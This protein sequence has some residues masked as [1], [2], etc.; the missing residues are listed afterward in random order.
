MGAYD[1]KGF[2]KSG[3]YKNMDSDNHGT[4]TWK[5][6]N[7]P[8]FSNQS[9]YHGADGW[10]GGN[11]TDKT[12]YQPSKQTLETY[13]PD[14]YDWMFKSEPGRSEYLDMSRY[15][16]GLNKP[17]PFVYQ[18]GGRTPIYVSDPDD[19]RLKAYN[20]STDAYDFGVRSIKE[21]NAAIKK[22]KEKGTPLKNIPKKH[23]QGLTPWV[24]TN[25]MPI[26]T[27]HASPTGTKYGSEN[28]DFTLW[29]FYTKFKKPVQPVQYKPAQKQVSYPNQ[30]IGTGMKRSISK[31]TNSI[32][33]SNPTPIY[34]NDPNDPRLK[35]YNDSL[36][37]Y[38]KEKR[39]Y[40]DETKL[41]Y[42][43]LLKYP[44]SNPSG[45]R[46]G[47]TYSNKPLHGYKKPVQ[48]IKYADPKIVAKQQQLIDA[49]YNIGT[50]DGIW[51][52]KSQQAWDQMNTPKQSNVNASF[53]TSTMPVRGM[54][55]EN[56]DA[57]KKQYKDE[58]G[59]NFKSQDNVF[60]NLQKSLG[61]RPTVTEYN[62][63]IQQYNS[64]VNNMKY[65]GWLDSYQEGG[66]II[67]PDETF[68]GIAN[69]YGFNKQELI[70][71]NP[72]LDI[73]KI[74]PGQKI[75][76]PTV[77]KI[78]EVNISS[79]NK[80]EPTSWYDYINPFNWGAPNYDD[81]GTFKQAFRKAR[82]EDKNDFM[83]Y[84]DRYSSDLAQLPENKKDIVK[85]NDIKI[86]R[87]Y[88]NDILYKGLSDV[89]KERRKKLLQS[90]NKIAN[91]QDNSEA[92]E[93]LLV[94]TAVMENTLGA[95]KNAYGRT[96]TRNPMSIDDI[97]YDDLFKVRKGAKDHTKSQKQA[98]DWLKTLG[99]DYR[100]MDKILRSDDP[101]AGMAAARLYYGRNTKPLPKE[102]NKDALYNYYIEA[103]NKGGV[104]KYKGK[105]GYKDKWDKYYN[106]VFPENT[107][108]KKYGGWLDSYQDGGQTKWLNNYK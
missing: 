42:D 70:N 63:A 33:K 58:F 66:H 12:G 65:G 50:A 56:V 54:T 2:W 52:K 90:A 15:E 18:K 72:G 3:D 80:K 40:E 55:E 98:F 81:A 49:G 17:T 53:S 67:Q 46:Y 25:I 51:G 105:S 37:L 59:A 13:G 73:D 85:S 83:Y 6:P 94:M 36:S 76:L 84:G 26:E 45:P 75:N 30:P 92:L 8:T 89:Q 61:R 31:N 104:D 9:K 23:N 41:S 14:Y 107:E 39:L 108:D 68:Y 102:N 19:P 87:D 82:I 106:L 99:Y 34:V 38:N 5:K 28:S 7:H 20:D 43:N 74:R 69:K 16:S 97:A 57:L 4:D 77:E 62:K 60:N 24:G 103:Y 1:V 11:W 78:E 32:Q 88:N 101:T 86:T 22:G 91:T 93:K 96:Y 47:Y 21:Y 10:Y 44:A 95:D 64:S 100:D 35:S 29:T 27:N 48:P 79:A 71:V